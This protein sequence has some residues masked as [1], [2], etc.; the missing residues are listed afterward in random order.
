MERAIAQQ[1]RTRI[2]LALRVIC[3]PDAKR[4]RGIL[5][6]RVELPI[7]LGPRGEW[8]IDGL[9]VHSA[10]IAIHVRAV[11]A[12]L[13]APQEVRCVPAVRVVA[14]DQR[15]ACALQRGGTAFV[16]VAADGSFAVELA[17]DV[18]AGSARTVE[19]PDR[20][21]DSQSRALETDEAEAAE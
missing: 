21:L 17:L 12:D 7:V 6:D 4:C 3:L 16:T 1:L 2:G 8:Q 20:E 10:P 11:L 13:G 19:A 14:A 15:I 9:L 5:P 18:A